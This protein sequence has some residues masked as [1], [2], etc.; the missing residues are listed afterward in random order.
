MSTR[1]F[2][3]MLNTCWKSGAFV[4]VGLD[5]DLNKIA[6]TGSI[7]SKLLQTNE[8]VVRATKNVACAYKPNI[9]FYEACGQAG[10]EALK[11]TIAFIHEVAPDV[12]IILDAKRADI[13]NTSE[14]YAYAAFRVFDADA[15]TVNPYFGQ[16]SIQPFL[17]WTD[18]GVIV[19]CRTSNP[20]SAEFQERLVQITDNEAEAWGLTNG[21]TMPIY[22]LVAWR[23]RRQWNTGGNCALVVGATFSR[24]LQAVR[25]IV[26]DM[27]ILVPGVGKQGGSIENVIKAGK[28]QRSLG[29]IINSSSG[30]MYADDPGAEALRMNDEIKHWLLG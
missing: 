19:L 30:I 22:Q 14:K 8:Y 7:Y 13:G 3:D 21:T 4:C 2:M 26:Q 24:E 11:A 17:D 20:G 5:P 6:K 18:K 29:L 15:V 28:D 23:V 12:P 27:P 1:K 9:A 10:L 25:Q 16:D